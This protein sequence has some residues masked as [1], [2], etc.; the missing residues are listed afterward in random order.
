M[1]E[2]DI[3]Q[4]NL[5]VDLTTNKINQQLRANDKLSE[6]I[7]RIL[8]NLDQV[9]DAVKK[10]EGYF[11]QNLST[12][13]TSIENE[14]KELSKVSDDFKNM[15]YKFDNF[16]DS[17]SISLK[18]F[19]DFIDKFNSSITELNT[20]SKKATE[21]L[22]ELH[23]DKKNFVFVNA[24]EFYKNKNKSCLNTSYIENHL[25]LPIYIVDFSNPK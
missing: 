15:H 18:N 2:D 5:L 17:H 23:E 12:H 13:I 8:V 20:N 14:C 22:N 7:Y 3:E 6:G 21:I 25:L 11:F 4:I 10:G 16:F 1:Q 9:K 19:E 24:F